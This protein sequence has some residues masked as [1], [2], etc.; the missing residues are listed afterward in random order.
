MDN[1]GGSFP[2][3][4]DGGRYSLPPLFPLFPPSHLC[5]IILCRYASEYGVVDLTWNNNFLS[6]YNP[7]PIPASS[8]L[9]L[10]SFLL[11]TSASSN[12]ISAY[13]FCQAVGAAQNV[14]TRYASAPDARYMYVYSSESLLFFQAF[15][16]TSLLRPSSN[17]LTMY[18][19]P[20]DGDGARYSIPSSGIHILK[21]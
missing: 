14:L 16:S 1:N 4:N 19:N 8:H 5:I 20:C 7:P 18:S 15:S 17:V 13:G 11:F 9:S 3:C 2:I 12:M 6:T 10:L 21:N